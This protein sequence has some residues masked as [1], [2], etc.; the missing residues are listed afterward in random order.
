MKI[1]FVALGT[2]N[3][4]LEYLSAYLKQSGHNTSLVFDRAL[5]NDSTY[6]NLP[7][8]GFFSK[9]PKKIAQEAL[10]TRPDIIGFSVL[11]STYQWSL[12]VAE[13]IKKAGNPLIVFGGAHPTLLPEIVINNPQVD[14]VCKGEGE[15]AILELADSLKNG[16]IN[17]SIAN[18]WFK[19][20]EAIIHNELGALISDLDKM[21]LPDKSLFEGQLPLNNSYLAVTSRGC[22]YGCAY[23]SEISMKQLYRNKGSYYR[24]KS[25]SPCINELQVMLQKYR[26]KC[27]D[28]RSSVLSYSKD[29]IKEFCRIYKEK[30]GLP[31]RI[32]LHPQ[33]IDPDIS[34]S[35]KDSGC[36]QVQVGIQTFNQDLR[37]KILYRPENN[38]DITNALD[39]LENAGLRFSVDLMT[40]LPEEDENDLDSAI[41]SL[42]SYRRLYKVA[43][44]YLQYLPGTPL[45]ESSIKNNTLSQ[46]DAQK[47]SQGCMENFLTAND[48]KNIKRLRNYQFLLR[49]M[50]A[51]NPKIF[52]FIYRKRLFLWIPDFI[53]SLLIILIDI[54]T[55]AWERDPFTFATIKGY[56]FE[57]IKKVNFK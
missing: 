4:G 46:E 13:E 18:L 50:P 32:M 36:W 21:P 19:K 48:T 54:V 8:L 45:L 24:E 11:T 49:I 31:Y 12:K 56:F 22:P 43:L 30:V 34:K 28:I 6:I 52:L 40:G 26:F 53:K 47:I 33:I 27:I 44:F 25:V 42:K 15:K 17:Y 2:E 35:L 16:K 57:L 39:C 38:L 14:V 51:L 10:K 7:F 23:C 37:K 29:W 3:I 41:L 5:F 55:A 9:S 20:D 1:T